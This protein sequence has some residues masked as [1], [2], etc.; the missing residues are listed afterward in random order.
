M[1]MAM[2]RP[3]VIR[4]RVATMGWMFSLDTRK[5]FHTP[6][7]AQTATAMRQAGSRGIWAVPVR[8][9]AD[10]GAAHGA[11]DGDNGALGNIDAA[12]GNDE[13]HARASTMRM[14]AR[15]RMSMTRPKS[16]PF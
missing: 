5:P 8:C 13:G 14:D 1:S 9:A 6:Q 15:F 2:P 4:I 10:K 7:T 16:C 3:A 11:G 12:G